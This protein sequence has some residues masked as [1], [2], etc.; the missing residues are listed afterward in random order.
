MA[1][2]AKA[3]SEAGYRFYALY[4]KIYREDVLAHAYAQCRSNKGAPGVDGQDFADVEA[5]GRERWL[6]ELAIALRE[7]NYRPE[8]IRRVWIPKAN[9]KLR[10]LGIPT[11]RDRVSMTAAM[12]VLEPIF[13]ADLPDEQYAYRQGRNA[14]QA[15]VEVEERLHRG[16]TDVVD[17]DLSDYFGSLPHA[18]L[19]KSLARRIVDRRVLHLIKMWLECAVE[20]TDDQG[21]K[22]RT[23]EAKDQGRGIPQGAPISPLLS[24]LYM[25]RFVLAWK[26]LGLESSLGSRILTYADDL[27]ILCRPGKAEEALHWMREIMGKLKLTVNEEKTRVCKVP[28]DTFDFLGFTFGRRYSPTTGKARMALW[29]SKKSIRRMTEKVHALTDLKTCWQETTELIDKLNRALRGWA[30]YFSVGNL[31]RAYRAL[32]SYTA[33]RLRRWLRNKYKLRRRRDGTYPLSHLY[34]HFGLVRL[35]ARGRSEAWVK[36]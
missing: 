29:P 21:R 20:E 6:A 11:L 10:P 3:K 17:A 8:P 33:P 26:R 14:Q 32:D 31:S 28:E 35:G 36:A 27:V 22:K 4:D 25:R 1:L 30:N 15:A 19:M 13:E 12:L 34:G 24:N 2:H 7:E 5:Y 23:T 16:Q 9:G 18:E